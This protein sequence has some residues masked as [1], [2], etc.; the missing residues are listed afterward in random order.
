MFMWLL[1]RYI[2][3]K[4]GGELTVLSL[5]FVAKVVNNLNINYRIALRWWN[6]YKDT[7]EIPYKKFE[8]SCGPKS[9]FTTKR[10]STKSIG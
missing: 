4:L 6:S 10:V 7:E 9:S 1:N 8:E 2:L 5:F 3:T